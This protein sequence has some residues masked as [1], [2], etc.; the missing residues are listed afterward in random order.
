VLAVLVAIPVFAGI[1]VL[2]AVGPYE[3]LS[4]LPE[5]DVRFV[6]HAVGE[7]RSDNGM[8]GLVADATFDDAEVGRPEVVVVPGGPGTRTLLDDE[9]LLGWLRRTHEHTTFTTSVCTGSLLLAAAGLLDGVDATTHWAAR[10]TLADLGAVPVDERV[11]ERGKVITAAGVSA[12]ID[13]ALV[14]AER[15]AGTVTAAAI[16]LQIEYDPHP[17]FD[18]GSLATATPDVVDRARQLAGGR[19]RVARS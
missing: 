15:L 14:L 4:R 13:M 12:G 10:R 1:T 11:V 5:T 8:L 17:P 16:Q 7:V 3:V 2:D 19:S 18:S 6:G 9:R